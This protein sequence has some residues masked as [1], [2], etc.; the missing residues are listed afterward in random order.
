MENLTRKMLSHWW[1]TYSVWFEGL[2]G[3]SRWCWSLLEQ[4]ESRK[5]EGLTRPL[6]HAQ[7]VSA[8]LEAISGRPGAIEAVA[9][10]HVDVEPDLKLGELGDPNANI[11]KGVAH[12]EPDSMPWEDIN[13]NANALVHLE[14]TAGNFD[15]QEGGRSAA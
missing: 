7:T 15:R 9:P 6:V 3:V 5:D 8:G 13:P 12:G 14:S 1:S 10:T 11:P 2:S 4:E